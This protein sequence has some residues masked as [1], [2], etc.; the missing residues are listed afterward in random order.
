V[1]RKKI[2]NWLASRLENKKMKVFYET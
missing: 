1:D 2:E